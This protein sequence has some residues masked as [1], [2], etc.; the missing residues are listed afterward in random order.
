MQILFFKAEGAVRIV[1]LRLLVCFVLANLL[2]WPVFT[3]LY[4]AGVAP[5]RLRAGLYR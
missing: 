3:L 4:T 5:G 1:A 2:F